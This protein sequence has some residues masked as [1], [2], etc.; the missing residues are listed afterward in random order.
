MSGAVLCLVWQGINYM[1]GFVHALPASWIAWQWGGSGWQQA[2]GPGGWVLHPSLRSSD[3]TGHADSSL[4][5]RA[6][7][8]RTSLCE[9]PDP[10]GPAF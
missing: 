6:A 3:P 1:H 9:R 2:A 5:L 4:K 8:A 7:L 10:A